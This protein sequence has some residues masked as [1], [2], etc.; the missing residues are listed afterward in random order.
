MG[1]N[2]FTKCVDYSEKGFWIIEEMQKFRENVTKL[3][4]VGF[5]KGRSDAIK[6]KFTKE[7]YHNLF[8]FLKEDKNENIEQLVE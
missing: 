3:Q 1:R 7:K 8:Q 6:N 4:L 2:T 5:L